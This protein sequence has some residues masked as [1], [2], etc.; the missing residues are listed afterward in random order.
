[1]T[2]H[3]VTDTLPEKSH[4]PWLHMVIIQNELK[5]ELDGLHIFLAPD[6]SLLTNESYL[7]I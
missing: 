5:P 7:Q 2:R 6:L 1:M 3:K 4:V